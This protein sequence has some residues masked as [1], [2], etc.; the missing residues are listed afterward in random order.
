MKRFLLFLT[1]LALTLA[2]VPSAFAQIQT[3][4]VTGGKVEGVITNGVA[5]FE[6][7]PFAAPPL[8]DLRWKAPQPVVPWTGT[9]KA[10]AFGPSPMQ[11][12]IWA[13]LMSSP[14]RISED[15]LYLNVWT[16]AKSPA[17]K[18]PVMVWIHG[19]GFSSG[20]TSAS[21]YDGTKLAQKGVVL[22][23]IAYRLGPFGFLATP[24][25]S[26]E[27]G[28]GSGNYGLLD[29]VA[30]LQWVRWNIR[31]FGACRRG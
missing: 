16:P 24:E 7:I 26:R 2:T 19:G 12:A 17:E 22:V 28:H 11:D 20:M 21:L 29:Q 4:T 1:L 8:R 3:A 10:D 25:L 6:G 23:S 15:C 31:Q 14:A 13:V 9:R 30:G 18:L 5:A 27:S